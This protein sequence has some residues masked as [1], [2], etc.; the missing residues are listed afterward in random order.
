MDEQA[1]K[2]LGIG[3]VLICLVVSGV[4]FYR[5]FFANSTGGTAGNRDIALLCKTCGGFEI[6]ADEFRDLMS[7]Q[8]PGMMMGMLGQQMTLDCPKCGKKTC[9]MAEKCEQ[10]ETIF[11]LGQAKDRNYPDRCPKCGF[12]RMEDRQKKPAP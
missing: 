3:L 10:C 11:V 9:Y 4:I 12:S 8:E 5:S 2:N 7:K 6:S 1:K